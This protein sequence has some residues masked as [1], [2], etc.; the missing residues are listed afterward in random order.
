MHGSNPHFAK[1]RVGERNIEERRAGTGRLAEFA[2]IPKCASL[3]DTSI[4]LEVESSSRQVVKRRIVVHSQTSRCAPHGVAGILEGAL[5]QRVAQAAN[6]R[7]HA[8][9]PH[10]SW[11]ADRGRVGPDQ[12]SHVDELCSDSGAERSA[13]KV[14]GVGRH[15]IECDSTA[16]EDIHSHRSK[17]AIDNGGSVHC[18]RSIN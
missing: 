9:T 1:T 8:F 2:L 10:Y 15:R 6:D 11:A 12:Q 4:R 13:E 7:H 14:C 17:G 3:K 5:A 16:S 18:Q